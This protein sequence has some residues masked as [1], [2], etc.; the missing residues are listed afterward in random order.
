MENDQALVIA[1][2]TVIYIVP[3]FLHSLRPFW[4]DELFTLYISQLPDLSTIWAA[5]KDGADQN[6][7]L[8][9]LLTRWSHQ[10]LGNGEAATRAPEILGFFTMMVCL[11]R[12]VSRRCGATFGFAAMVFPLLTG[13]ETY[14]SEARSYG[15]VL[16]F[17]GI[18]MIAWQRA[19]EGR[20]RTFALATLLTSLCGA[21]LVHAYAVFLLVA[22]AV[23]EITRALSRHKVDWAM[24]ICLAVPTLC[25]LT[26]L[27]I[28]AAKPWSV[29]PGVDRPNWS[30]F[31]DFYW[32]LLGPSMWPLLASLI[33]VLALTAPR[34]GATTDDAG[35]IPLHES[36]LALSLALLPVFAIAVAS[37]VTHVWRHRYGVAAAAGITVLLMFFLWNRSG[38]ERAAGAALFSIL[39]VPYVLTNTSWIAG[40]VRPDRDTTSPNIHLPPVEEVHPELPL[41]YS[42]ALY[43]LAEDHYASPNVVS[44]LYFLTDHKASIDF[45]G[46]DFFDTQLPILKKWLPIRGKI[47]DYDTFMAEHERF[48]LYGAFDEPVDWVVRKLTHDHVPMK[49]LGQYPE[50]FKPNLLLEVDQHFGRQQTGRSNQ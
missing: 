41:V 7:P 28:L 44:R 50:L 13:A 40:V 1:F 3:T 27:P 2:V 5:L 26:Y 4:Y 31:L 9:F 43:F 42:T 32:F 12:F 39:V 48:L 19:A 33:L 38:G 30:S 36:V 10:L 23:A 6:P 35:R 21:L 16:G 11:F 45:S 29:R 37:T 24:S 20:N 8:L 22:F 14:A 25:V 47:V 34:M 46:S 15:L 49:F 18:S 17:C